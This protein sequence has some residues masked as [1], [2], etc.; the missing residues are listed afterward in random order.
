MALVEEFVRAYS[1]ALS[2]HS[3][4]VHDDLGDQRLR[5]ESNDKKAGP[6]L[7]LSLQFPECVFSEVMLT[8]DGCL[9]RLGKVDLSKKS[10]QNCTGRCDDLRKFD[11]A[12][13]F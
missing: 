10:M 11:V 3:A 12:V 8:R 9:N 4:A 5:I 7:T 6:F 1:Q 2:D 13:L